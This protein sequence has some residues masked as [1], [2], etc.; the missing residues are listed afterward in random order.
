MKRLPVRFKGKPLMPKTSSRVSKFVAEGR[1]KIR[2]N[3]KLKLHYLQ[4]LVE[5]SGE[6]TQDITL[7][8]D[9]GSTF[10]GL[11]VVSSKCHHCNYELIQRPKVGKNSIK[12]FKKRQSVNRRH[13]RTKLR[14]RPIRFDNRTSKKLPP[15]IQANV[16]FRKWI[17][18]KLINYFPVSK[19]VVEDVRFNHYKSTKGKSFSLVEQGKTQ[20]YKFIRNLGIRL[21]TYSGYDTKNLRVNSFGYDTKIKTKGSQTFEAHCIDS[22]VLACNKTNLVDM[23]T[24]EVSGNQLI[25]TND[26]KIY[27]KV[28]FIEKIVKIRRCLTRIRKLYTSSSRLEGGNYYRKLKGGVKEV[29]NN[30]SGKSNIVRVKPK[31]EHSNH[32]KEWIYID[33]GKDQRFKCSLAP[34]GGTRING[35]SFLVKGEW[36]NRKVWGSEHSSTMLKTSWFYAQ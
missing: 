21:E 28:T 23:N 7:G 5:P 10:D 36:Q 1:G 8:I 35:K 2:Y 4:L 19:I 34:Y 27:K 30:Y 24:G 20:L 16:D 11:S 15:T 9:P 18:G 17:I 29:Y 25:I 26:L 22:F 32:P 12:S 13:R 3:R 31:D 14:H 33:N 6:D